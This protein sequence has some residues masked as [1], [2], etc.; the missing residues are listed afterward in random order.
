MGWDE[1]IRACFLRS[2][3]PRVLIQGKQEDM[4]RTISQGDVGE[5]R[6]LYPWHRTKRQPDGSWQ[7]EMLGL[8]LK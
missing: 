8:G 1:L 3:R 7:A 5:L 2:R 4:I 6:P